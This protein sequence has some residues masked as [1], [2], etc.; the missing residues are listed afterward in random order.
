MLDLLQSWPLVTR[1]AMSDTALLQKMVLQQQIT[2]HKKINANQ[3][4]I[5]VDVSQPDNI[6]EQKD[7]LCC[8]SILKHE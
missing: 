7:H 5:S 6:Q 8:T 3:G 2:S 4:Q 1:W